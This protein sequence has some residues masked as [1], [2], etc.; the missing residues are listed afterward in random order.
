MK[1]SSRT[2]RLSRTSR[3]DSCIRPSLS[4]MIPFPATMESIESP[5]SRP[6]RRRIR[7]SVWS[8]S[9]LLKAFCAISFST[10]RADMTVLSVAGRPS[11]LFRISSNSC[12]RCL[13]SIYFK[14]VR[15]ESTR[16]FQPFPTWLVHSIVAMERLSSLRTTF[17]IRVSL[18]PPDAEKYL[19]LNN[20]T[21]CPGNN[22]IRFRSI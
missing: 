6:P 9:V 4:A 11:Q 20:R 12:S 15:L 14:S 3:R 2:V 22:G 7:K 10:L 1:I 17:V 13:S 16:D 21:R 18:I 19:S 5:T 8:G